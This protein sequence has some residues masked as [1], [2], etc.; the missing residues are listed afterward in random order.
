MVSIRPA[1]NDIEAE[2]DFGVGM[3]HG[4]IASEYRKMTRKTPFLI[5]VMDF[6]TMHEHVKNGSYDR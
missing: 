5:V 4:G 3:H 1:R 2:V 6:C